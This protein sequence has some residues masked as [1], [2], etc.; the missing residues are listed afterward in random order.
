M[1]QTSVIL[2]INTDLFFDKF[3]PLHPYSI[4]IFRV[5][6]G[7]KHADTHVFISR[8]ASK[9]RVVAQKQVVSK[10]LCP[11]CGKFLWLVSLV[12]LIYRQTC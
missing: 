4:N 11:V 1:Y 9:D 2:A 7:T 3:A 12:L 5:A 10:F 8:T 6:S